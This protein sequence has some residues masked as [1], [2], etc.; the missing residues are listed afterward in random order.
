MMTAPLLPKLRAAAV[1][2]SNV[3]CLRKGV[4]S[5]L[6]SKE[7][8]DG[9]EDRVGLGACRIAVFHFLVGCL[10]DELRGWE[11]RDPGGVELHLAGTRRC[12]RI[13]SGKSARLQIFVGVAV[14]RNCLP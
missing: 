7:E 3:T 1:N 13:G 10:E 9:A 8:P 12:I 2:R 5:V 11:D 6:T 14:E 4:S